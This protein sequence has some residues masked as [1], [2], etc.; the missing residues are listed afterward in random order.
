MH[1][2]TAGPGPDVAHLEAGK[3]GTSQPGA[4]AQQD[5]GTVPGPGRRGREC[6]HQRLELAPS[7]RLGGV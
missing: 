6:V 5:D 4:Y 7:K 2:E 1:E 3:L